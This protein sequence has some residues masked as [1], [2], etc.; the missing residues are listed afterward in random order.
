MKRLVC[1]L[2]SSALLLGLSSCTATPNKNLADSSL[3]DSS[4][5]DQ[6]AILKE[7]SRA[8]LEQ[9]QQGQFD[10]F[11][12]NTAEEFSSQVP[13]ETFSAQWAAVMQM[14]GAQEEVISEECQE[15]NGNISVQITATHVLRRLISTFAY[16]TDEKI[17]GT[18]V[19]YQPLVVK[20]Q[21]TDQWEESEIQVGTGGKSLMGC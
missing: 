8:Y 9:F 18:F 6:T 16:N 7:K 2:L 21:S 12:E 5:A 17:I 15:E 13:K 4:A 3:A 1:V 19:A 10:E 14:A 11:Y 20:P